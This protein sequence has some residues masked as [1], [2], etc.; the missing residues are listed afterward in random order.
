MKKKL[1]ILKDGYIEDIKD[2]Y[3]VVTGGCPTC[4]LDEEYI[5]NIQ[6]NICH[7]NTQHIE[8]FE[9]ESLDYCKFSFSVA[10]IIKLILNNLNNFSEMTIKEFKIFMEEKL[11]N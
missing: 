1:V 6:F 11:L 9:I 3:D 4:G 2:D 10:D 8:C 7:N 5:S